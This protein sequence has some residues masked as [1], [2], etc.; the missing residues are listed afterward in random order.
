MKNKRVVL[1]VGVGPQLGMSVARRFGSAGYAVALISRSQQKCDA[2]AQELA[3]QGI[4]AAGFAADVVDQ[5][6]LDEAV[7]KVIARFGRVDVLEY[8]P[9]ISMASLRQPDDLEVGIVLYNMQFQLFGAIT[10][11]NRILPGML[12][13]GEGALLF[14]TGASA[15]APM[16]SHCSGSLAVTALRHYAHMLNDQLA[17]RGIYAGTICIAKMHEGPE[18]AER[19]WQMTANRAPVEYVHGNVDEVAAFEFFVAR[20]QAIGYPPLLTAQPA[21]PQDEHER[22][23]LLLALS[24]SR[25]NG[26]AHLRSRGD[27]LVEAS[28]LLQNYPELGDADAYLHRLDA[29][30]RTH[31]GDPADDRYGVPHGAYRWDRQ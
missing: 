24:H 16:A 22:L 20:N 29:L 18:L 25:R 2:F 8:S 10:V 26:Q 15:I 6:A 14:T 23:R 11:V 19:Y 1:V 3:A 27:G 12:E 28:P 4:E 30:A 13:R 5:K 31:G 7:G 17:T 9:L 21:A